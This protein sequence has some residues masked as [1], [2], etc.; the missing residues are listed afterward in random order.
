M[1]MMQPRLDCRIE[2]PFQWKL[3][4]DG[5]VQ[6]QTALLKYLVSS[7]RPGP[8]AGPSKLWAS[9]N[10]EMRLY[11]GSVTVNRI[12]DANFVEQVELFSFRCEPPW[13]SDKS[14]VNTFINK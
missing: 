13:G 14:D 6:M 2:G 11:Y 1:Q 9:S 12:R 10:G 5:R 4:K 3:T 8:L 7:F